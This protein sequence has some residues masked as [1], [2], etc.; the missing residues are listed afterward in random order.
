MK[1]KSGLEVLLS[2]DYIRIGFESL[3]YDK[4]GQICIEDLR[5]NFDEKDT[6]YAAKEHNENVL[7]K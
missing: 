6:I 1:I 7:E 2:E 3:D 4:N 5:A